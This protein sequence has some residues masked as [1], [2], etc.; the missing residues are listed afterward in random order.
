MREDDIY[1]PTFLELLNLRF[2]LRQGPEPEWFGGVH[3]MADLQAKFQVF[4]KGRPFKQSASLLGLGGN[5]NSRARTRWFDY[6][7]SLA[8]YRSNKPGQNGDEAIVGALME[9]LASASLLP[10]HFK[11]YDAGADPDWRVIVGEEPRPLF[12]VATDY[13]TISLPMRPRS[14]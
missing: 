4:Q 9:N 2:A 12:Y 11:A 14:T 8:K 13:L 7:D 3:E 6:L 10:V 5:F 1:V